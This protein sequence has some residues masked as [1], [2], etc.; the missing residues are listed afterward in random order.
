MAQTVCIPVSA[1]LIC[2]TDGGEGFRSSSSAGTGRMHFI[3][4]TVGNDTYFH[5]AT[6][7]MD[8]PV[9]PTMTFVVGKHLYLFPSSKSE[10]GLTSDVSRYADDMCRHIDNCFDVGD[11]CAGT[12]R[13]KLTFRADTGGSTRPVSVF[14]CAS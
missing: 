13:Q 3:H 8:W 2:S 4:S 5:F 9:V 11:P 6:L 10:F 7:V 12:F 14:S 1:D